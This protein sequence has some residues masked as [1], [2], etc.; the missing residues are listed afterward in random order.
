MK[1]YNITMSLDE[2][3]LMDLANYIQLGLDIKNSREDEKDVKAIQG[4]D[5][6][7]RTGVYNV[8]NGREALRVI[9][10]T[11]NAQIHEDN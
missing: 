10:N 2:N 8:F 5:S 11:F 3:Q 4:S 9:Y 6:L 7:R 1:T